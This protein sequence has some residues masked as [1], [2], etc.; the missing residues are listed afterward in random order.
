[1]VFCMVA[2]GGLTRLTESGLSITS[3]KPI[4]GIFPPMSE[5]A[6]QQE[7]TAYQQT[8]E[9]N[10]KNFGMELS[11]FKNIFWLEFL[12]RLLGRVTGLVFFIP[13]IYF[14]A[15]KRLETNLGIKLFGIFL[16]GGLQGIIGW[17]MV[18]SGLVD[19]PRVSP[20]RLALHLVMAVII[21]GLL[22]WNALSLYPYK[23]IKNVPDSIRKFS[24]VVTVLIFLQIIAGAFVAGL[25]AGLTYN[26]FP[27]MDGKFIP[28]G[29]MAMEP[30]LINLFENV[31]TVQF[32][33]RIIAYIVALSVMGFWLFTIKNTTHKG[34]IFPV[35]LLFC[36]MALQVFLGVITLLN[37]VPIFLASLHQI[38][39]L[40]LFSVSLFINWI[41]CARVRRESPKTAKK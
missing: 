6:W 40:V 7:F 14:W 17:Y 27:L 11:G 9:F 25:D 1:M 37:A 10:K 15:T 3:W 22:L 28:D 20:Y 5:E 31:A 36:I 12:H 16:L 30:R 39:A 19:D 34:I 33:H 18:K 13:L 8:P 41:L 35:N 4:S 32:N 21:L 29:L 24:I 23:N 2:I 26:T 38:C